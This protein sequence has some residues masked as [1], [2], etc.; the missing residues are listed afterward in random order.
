MTDILTVIAKEWKEYLQAR[1]SKRG[2]IMMF[3]FP[4][5]LFGVVFPLQA[6]RDWIETPITILSFSWIPLLFVSAVT[7][8]SFAGERERH[9]LE[10]LL[11]S[12]LSEK[13]ILFGKT[14]AAVSYGILLTGLIVSAGL[15]TVNIVHAEDGLVLY[16]AKAFLGGSVICLLASLFIAGL[17]IL[18]SLKAAT[19]RQA[20]Q[21][22]SIG[23]IAV[24]FLPTLLLSVFPSET[25]KQ[26]ISVLDSVDA[27]SVFLV[28]VGFLAVIDILILTVAVKRFT[29]SDMLAQ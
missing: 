27:F 5:V 1:G 17:G 23:L 3:L 8:D 13:A 25:R 14:I 7:A 2:T 19:V 21:T 9:T 6:G 18:V 15:A 16:P 4:V 10:T 24:A 20:H 26:I 11:A 22:M 28:V 29:R 12:R